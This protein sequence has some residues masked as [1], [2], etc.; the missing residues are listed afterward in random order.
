MIVVFAFFMILM[1]VSC[2]FALAIEKRKMRPN[3][4]RIH[5][6]SL[7]AAAAAAFSIGVF[8]ARESL[9]N[10]MDAWRAPAFAFVAVA[11]IA[12]GGVQIK[13]AVRHRYKNANRIALS[14]FTFGIGV[15]TL[16]ASL[17]FLLGFYASA[18]AI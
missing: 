10:R 8:A 18:I 15:L 11:L 3:A 16:I 14:S 5:S 6:L 9:L 7:E 1:T 4:L 12:I 17:I 2:L 13:I